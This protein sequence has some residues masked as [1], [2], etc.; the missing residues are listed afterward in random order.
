MLQPDVP[1]LSQGEGGGQQ[2]QVNSPSLKDWLVRICEGMDVAVSL[3]A[4]QLQGHLQD[5]KKWIHQPSKEICALISWLDEHG[6]FYYAAGKQKK[7]YIGSGPS[8]LAMACLDT[9]Q[10]IVQSA[11][12]IVLQQSHLPLMENIPLH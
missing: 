12:V 5:T 1:H 7:T 3:W 4:T 6:S 11:C 2:E 8:V 9:D 10:V